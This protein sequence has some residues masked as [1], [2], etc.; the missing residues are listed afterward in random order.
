VRY[1]VYAYGYSGLDTLNVVKVRVTGVLSDLE[2]PSTT[3]YYERGDIIESKTLGIALTETAANNWF[4]NISTSYDVKSVALQDISNF[5]YSVTTIDPHNFVVGDSAKIFGSNGSERSCIVIQII[6]KNT[7][8]IKGQGQLDTQSNYT[9]QKLLS[10][11]NS[12]NY[13]EYENITV[14]NNTLLSCGGQANTPGYIK[15]VNNTYDYIFVNGEITKMQLID[16]TKAYKAMYTS[17]GQKLYFSNNLSEFGLKIKPTNPVTLYF[18]E[19]PT[20]CNAAV[21]IMFNVSSGA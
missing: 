20:P 14:Y 16:E 18:N 12:S 6:N 2:L 9:I 4:F 8:I 15:K 11:V 5:T 1:D 13:P 19:S 10:K 21:L 3:R 7:F 17:N